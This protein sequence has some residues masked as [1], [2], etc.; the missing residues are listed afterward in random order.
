[1]HDDE[2][3]TIGRFARLSQVSVHTLRHYDEI[4]LL[5]PA[6][7]DPASGYRRYRRAQIRVARL[8]QVLRGLDLP[9]EEVRPMLSAGTDEVRA[10]PARHRQRL[11]RQRRQLAERI[12]WVDRFLQEGI[13]VPT[14]QT[15]CRPV[16]TVIPVADRDAAVAFYREA[17]RFPYD[18]IRRTKHRDHLGFTFGTYGQDDFFLLH[19][20]GPERSDRPAGPAV[21]GLLVDDLDAHHARA[22]SA[23]ASEAVAPRDAEGM[24]RGSAVRDPSGNTIG[25]AQG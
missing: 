21:F 3:M 10:V 14:V 7:I 17:F 6:E 4:G 20:R 11:D 22:L 25:L 9:I 2:L 5:A 24:P 18:V 23:G 1:M 15:G 12:D 16:Q 8:I 19:A 13:T